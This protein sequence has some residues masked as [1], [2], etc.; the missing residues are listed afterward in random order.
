MRDASLRE[1]MPFSDGATTAGLVG[2]RRWLPVILVGLLAFVILI[3]NLSFRI[4]QTGEA[5]LDWQ[6]GLKLVT[7]ATLFAV[8]VFSWRRYRALFAD[9][10]LALA[11]CYGG[12][13]LLSSLYSVTPAYSAACAFGFLAYLLIAAL[14]AAELDGVTL[15]AVV[16]W[17]FSAYLAASWIAAAVAPETAFLA[18]YG[19]NQLF[20]RLQGLSGHPNMLGKQV[21]S[22]VC[23][24][25]GARALRWF[26]GR[27]IFAAMLTV[28]MVTLVATG[29]RTALVSLLLSL[30]LVAIRTHRA[31]L[32][33]LGLLSTAAGLACLA[34]GLGFP[35]F[36][37][38]FE[39][40]SRTGEAHEITSLT[41]RVRLWGFVWQNFLDRPLLGYGFNST[42]IV[43]APSWPGPAD[44]IAGAH[45]TMLQSLLTVGVIGTIPLLAMYLLMIGRF[46]FS[47][48]GISRYLL[49]YSVIVSL[50]EI[51]VSSVPVFMTLVLFLALSIDAARVRFLST[52]HPSP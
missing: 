26:P 15:V 16:A 13:G 8:A 41:G 31:G 46:L 35:V 9:W 36:E 25:L 2:P 28:A 48:P 51:E 40:G 39:L 27:W 14:L 42:D 32:A 33:F 19:D 12:F 20:P 23:F 6:N 29:S 38:L 22:F 5:G 52:L 37:D 47:V 11:L 30:I 4:R 17:S 21:S 10:M 18:T 1:R 43:L 44:Q 45:N 3:L 24:M 50:T 7:W 34:D 49:P